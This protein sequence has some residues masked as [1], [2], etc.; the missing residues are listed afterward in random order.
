M[1]F[2]HVKDAY[3][4]E[5]QQQLNTVS[6]ERFCQNSALSTIFSLPKYRIRLSI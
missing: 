1:L 4:R 2:M 3:V 5:A 6:I